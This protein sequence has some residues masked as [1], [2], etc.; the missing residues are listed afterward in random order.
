MDILLSHPK[1]ESGY[2]NL[3]QDHYKHDIQLGY[4]SIGP[5]R[6]DLLF[7]GENE[8]TIEHFSQGQKR[9][10]VIALRIAQFHYLKE[11]LQIQPI[12]LIDDIFGELDNKRKEALI[13]LLDRCGQAII[14]TPKIDDLG[15]G[16]SGASETEEAEIKQQSYVYYI[17]S[18]N[19]EIQRV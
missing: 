17:S 10:L 8:I 12:L 5:H 11:V 4:T 7:K 1:E 6:H 13:K 15:L 19:A 14:T 2:L 9:S 3:L 18:V 16:R